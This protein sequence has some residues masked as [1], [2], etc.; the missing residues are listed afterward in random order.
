MPDEIPSRRLAFAEPI[1]RIEDLAT[2]G[3]GASA[4]DSAVT[5]PG[6]PGRSPARPVLRRVDG[7]SAA[8]RAG[9]ASPN[10]DP[11]HLAR[12][13][14]EP[15]P[16]IDPGFGIEEMCLIA[17]RVEP[18][19]ERQTTAQGIGRRGGGGRS[20]PPRRSPRRQAWAAQRLSPRAGRERLARALDPT[21]PAL[22]P[23]AA[24]CLARRPS[25]PTSASRAARA[26]RRHGARAR[27]P[28]G[29]LRVAARSS[30]RRAR[31]RARARLRRVV[32]RRRWPRRC[33][34]TTAS[35]PPTA[36]AT[37]SSAT[38]LRSKACDGSCTGSSHDLR[39]ASGHDP[40]QLPARRIERRGTVRASC[41]ARDSRRSAS[42]IA[43]RLPGSCG[44]TMPRRPRA[45]GSSSDAVSTLRTG[46]RCWSIRRTAPPTVALCR[47]LSIGKGRAGKGACRLGWDDVA[48]W[49]EGQIVVFVPAS[50][51]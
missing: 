23:P 30:P 2:G 21:S 25:T 12:L 24:G 11:A 36:P 47:L 19:S 40:L 44:P 29:L 43:T 32:A 13:F 51:R 50:D 45:F 5:S 4:S 26:D 33:A 46:R 18:L 49:G 16:C 8:L 3:R 10:R 27:L 15:S 34:T 9:T 17:S 1:G 20:E 31:G 37:G 38:G 41:D 7:L 6:G 39:R 42:S 14:D 48:A 28:A 22:A 35:R